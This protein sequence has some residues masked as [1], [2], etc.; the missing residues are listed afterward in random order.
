T[1]AADAD[2]FRQDEQ[3]KCGH[4]FVV[5]DEFRPA[6]L[7]TG[8]GNGQHIETFFMQEL[9][10]VRSINRGMEKLKEFAFACADL[11][12][13]PRI[14]G[15]EPPV[16]FILENGDSRL[17]LSQLRDLPPEVRHLGERGMKITRF[18]GLGEMDPEEL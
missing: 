3:T 8:N 11:V 15:R 18:K 14:A 4:D 1:S 13:L 10:E 9:H 2:K 12:P 17:L 5:A 6:M 7:P 16:R